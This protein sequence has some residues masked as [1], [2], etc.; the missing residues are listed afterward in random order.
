MAQA[1]PMRMKV[2]MYLADEVRRLSPR[3]ITRPRESLTSAGSVV[4]HRSVV[5]PC[6]NSLP[7]LAV[8]ANREP[9]ISTMMGKKVA[10]K[11]MP[12]SVG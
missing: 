5:Y 4:S 12:Q 9:T 2:C 8:Q 6:R 10:K 1:A 7:A 11:R 3:G